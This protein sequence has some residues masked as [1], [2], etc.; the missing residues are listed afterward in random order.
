MT[1]FDFEKAT[2]GMTMEEIIKE[3]GI[4]DEGD[5]VDEEDLEG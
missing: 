4:A 2:E 1:E 5:I 3:F